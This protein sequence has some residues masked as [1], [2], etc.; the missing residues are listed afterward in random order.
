MFICQTISALFFP[1]P[2]KTPQEEL[3]LCGPGKPHYWKRS[4]VHF[5]KTLGNQ[6]PND[7][8][9]EALQVNF[10]SLRAVYG[11]TTLGLD[12]KP[13][14]KKYSN[15]KGVVVSY[16]AQYSDKENAWM[17]ITNPDDNK[18]VGVILSIKLTYVRIKNQHDFFRKKSTVL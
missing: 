5:F 15:R 10:Y 3:D 9:D 2:S 4:K 7:H 12:A 6:T 1:V 16:T 18:K 17:D 13:G 14:N 8:D 11:W